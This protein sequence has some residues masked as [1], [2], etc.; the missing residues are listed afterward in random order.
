MTFEEVY[1]DSK[2]L[3]DRFSSL[4]NEMVKKT[5]PEKTDPSDP[6]SIELN[7]LFTQ[8]KEKEEPFLNDFL[9]LNV[10]KTYYPIACFFTKYFEYLRK[11]G[12]TD[13]KE[14]DDNMVAMMLVFSQAQRDMLEMEKSILLPFSMRH[15]LNEDDMVKKLKNLGVEPSVKYDSAFEQIFAK[16][17]PEDSSLDAKGIKEVVSLQMSKFNEILDLIATPGFD[18]ENSNESK[19]TLVKLYDEL[20]AIEETNVRQILA[21]MLYQ[22]FIPIKLFEEKVLSDNLAL[23]RGTAGPL[24]DRFTKMMDELKQASEKFFTFRDYFIKSFCERH[25]LDLSEV[26]EE[27]FEKIDTYKNINIRDTD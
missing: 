26:L 18:A 3:R 23:I 1:K 17:V 6:I 16:D 10:L 25:D 14:Y 27:V 4:M 22:A 24:K 12:K 8:L 21:A 2:E 9:T 5:E 19:A 20:A 11:T 7:S 13:T 15:G